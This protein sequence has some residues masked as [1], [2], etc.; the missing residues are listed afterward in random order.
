MALATSLQRQGLLRAR[1]PVA[2]RPSVGH[3]RGSF[4]ELSWNGQHPVHLDDGSE[5]SFLSDGDVVTIRGTAPGPGR[6]TIG[7]GEVTGQVLPAHP[8]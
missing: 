4:L 1:E 6:A 5:R 2:H 7:L 3:E 8:G